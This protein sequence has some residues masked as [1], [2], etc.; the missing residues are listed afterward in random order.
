M[1]HPLR[2]SIGGNTAERAIRTFKNHF[3]AILYGTDPQFRLHLW[4]QLLRQTLVTLNLLRS[5]WINP[6]LSAQAQIHGAFDFN[7]TPLGPLGTKS[8]AHTKPTMRES[9][10]PHGA[11]GWY[12]SSATKHYRCHQV[13]IS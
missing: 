13:Y 7:N 8:I 2:T 9:W 11:A 5:S 10:A 6:C 3:I 4:D 1:K 12:I